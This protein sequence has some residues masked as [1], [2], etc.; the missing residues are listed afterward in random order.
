[1][2][3]ALDS[4]QR[5]RNI[6]QG[7]QYD[8][9]IAV[10]RRQI[11]PGDNGS[12]RMASRGVVE[13]WVLIV[14]SDRLA[15]QMRCQLAVAKLLRDDAKKMKAV[16]VVRVDREKFSVAVFGFRELAGLMMPPSSRQEVGNLSRRT[17]DRVPPY[18]RRGLVPALSCHSPLFSVHREGPD[19]ANP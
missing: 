6:A 11:T 17:E 3:A 12:A 13:S 5:R 8:G 18:R 14:Q 9:E 19:R 10:R 7:R 1:M 4:F 2:Q 16:K 15:D